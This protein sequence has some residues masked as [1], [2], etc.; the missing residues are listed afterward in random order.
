MTARTPTAR[1]LALALM[2]HAARILPP[3]R[4]EW[5]RAMQHE[6]SHIP[7]DLDALSWAVGC[8]LASYVERSTIMNVLHAWYV[9]A[10]LALMVVGLSVT[11]FFATALT[12]TYRLQYLRAAR[13]LGSV[14]PGDDY[15]RFIPL[16]DATPWWLHGMW[17]AGGLLCIVAAF[18]LLRGRA[19]AFLL[20]A[21]AWLLGAVA[22]GISRS[23]PEFGQV[24]SFSEPN[25]TRDY[26]IPA[27][28]A[29]VP[30]FVAAALWAHR[31]WG[32]G[33]EANG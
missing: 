17:V 19:G 22:D 33:L 31:R 3:A 29:L 7:R 20:F 26:V 25:V 1:R 12:L 8:V 27:I 5:A 15:R 9:R 23:M 28:T 14:T 2:A 18:Q 6:I 16:M 32:V 24:F 21:A 11:F 10:A 13:F 4:S 30:V